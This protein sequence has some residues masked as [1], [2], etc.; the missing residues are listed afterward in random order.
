MGQLEVS[1][2]IPYNINRGYLRDAVESAK[3]QVFSE[4]FEVIVQQGDFPVSKN[5]NDALKKAKGRFIKL[6]AED[7]ILNLLCLKTLYDKAMQSDCDLVCA[8]A[9]NRGKDKEYPVKSSIPLTIQELAYHNTIHGLTVLFR[10]ES[11]PVFNESLCTGEEFEIYLR[12]ADN[13]CRFGY[14]DK[15][16]GIYR[17]HDSQKS[18]VYVNPNIEQAQKRREYIFENIRKKYIEN[19]K[20]IKR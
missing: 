11:L 8:N 9:T 5:I 20:K 19:T 7:D 18:A 15:N 1:I 12:M 4:P 17:L 6:C 2:I 14:I 16:V 13:D 3:N 10:R